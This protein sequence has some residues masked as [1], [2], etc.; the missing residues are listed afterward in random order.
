MLEF[1][2]FLEYDSDSEGN[3]HIRLGNNGR[4]K[5]FRFV[6]LSFWIMNERKVKSRI[7]EPTVYIPYRKLKYLSQISGF[8]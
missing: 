6:I 7:E 1:D 5:C 8:A 3:F 2:G 4:Q